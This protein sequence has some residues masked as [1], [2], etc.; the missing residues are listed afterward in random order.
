M[1]QIVDTFESNFV[2][3]GFSDKICVDTRQPV[4]SQKVE[5]KDAFELLMSGGKTPNSS[6]SKYNRGGKGQRKK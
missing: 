4:E 5:K 2:E 1:S 6:K 3:G